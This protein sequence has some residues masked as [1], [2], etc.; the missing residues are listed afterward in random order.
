MLIEIFDSPLKGLD[1]WMLEL[2]IMYYFNSKINQI[3]LYK[4][5]ILSFMMNIIPCILKIIIIFALDNLN[6]SEDKKNIYLKYKWLI[7]VGIIFY[8]ILYSLNSYIILSLR[9]LID[10]KNI[11]PNR[12]LISYS[13]IGTLIYS[14]MSIIAT[15]INC[16]N[17]YLCQIEDKN[18]NYKEKFKFIFFFI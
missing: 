7:A 13:I 10:K 5:H 1:F 2:L 17:K 11:S 3:K 16:N 14:I 4:H 6:T 12:F 8:L 15:Y 18:N 9:W